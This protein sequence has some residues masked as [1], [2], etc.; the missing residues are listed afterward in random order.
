LETLLEGFKGLMLCTSATTK[1]P[2]DISLMKTRAYVKLKTEGSIICE[3][4]QHHDGMH[5]NK[6]VRRHIKS[7][8]WHIKLHHIWVLGPDAIKEMGIGRILEKVVH[9]FIKLNMLGFLDSFTLNIVVNDLLHVLGEAE[10]DANTSIRDSL[11]IAM[12]TIRN[13]IN[14]AA[15][16]LEVSMVRT[17]ARADLIWSI[18]TAMM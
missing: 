12:G 16:G 7:R 2:R 17:V 3:V 13:G 8:Q 15:K 14:M 4:K 6:C 10:E 1:D 11:G 5:T 9:A 18:V